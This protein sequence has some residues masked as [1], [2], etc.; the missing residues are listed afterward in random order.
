MVRAA[1]EMLR[2]G[3]G[4]EGAMSLAAFGDCCGV[5]VQA[6]S[7]TQVT[8]KEGHMPVDLQ[9]RSVKQEGSIDDGEKRANPTTTRPVPHSAPWS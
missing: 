8:E 3:G 2:S 6:V 5:Q 9:E 1:W 7:L 4:R